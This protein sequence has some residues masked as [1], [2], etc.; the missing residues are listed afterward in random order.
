MSTSSIMANFE[1]RDSKAARAFVDGL[2]KAYRT[3]PPRRPK[4]VQFV[5]VTDRHAI[6]D[7]ITINELNAWLCSLD[8]DAVDGVLRDVDMYYRLEMNI[9]E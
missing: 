5:S 3:R 4:N 7:V 8:N 2:W 6:E 9:G 1:I